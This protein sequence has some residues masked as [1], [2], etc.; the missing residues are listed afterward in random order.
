[1]RVCILSY[2]HPNLT[3]KCVRSTLAHVA[4]EDILL[5]H[6]GSDPDSI[7]V[8]QREFPQI[9]HLVIA[10]NRGFSGGANA[11]LRH[12]FQTHSWAFFITN[13]CD[14]L[15]TPA[16][17]SQPGLF[18]PLIY[19][20]SRNKIDSLGAVFYPLTGKLRHFR[21]KNIKVSSNWR[22]RFYVPGTA[23]F[24]DRETFTAL[25]GFD[26]TLHTY[27]EDVD[28]SV[29][30]QQKGLHIGLWPQTELTHKVGKTCHKHAFYTKI[31]FQR[32]RKIVSRRYTP[33]WISPLQKLW[34]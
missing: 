12:V 6:N 16:I 26:E 15:N 22:Q 29:R 5:A 11:T 28:F 18:A 20:R 25:N 34:L 13:D 31:L 21:E 7:R 3:A 27:W 1:M 24:I 19:R 32:N 23:F 2:N 14:L 10:H 17:P 4:P 33:S 9:E 8:L 30:L